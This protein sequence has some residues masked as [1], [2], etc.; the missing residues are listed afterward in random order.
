[1]FEERVPFSGGILVMKI[2]LRGIC[3]DDRATH[4]DA[5][6]ASKETG[7]KDECKVHDIPMIDPNKLHNPG[8]HFQTK[9]PLNYI[10]IVETMCYLAPLSF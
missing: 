5:V 2:I 6:H 1:M 8:A 4:P 10:E 3:G 9:I 7:K